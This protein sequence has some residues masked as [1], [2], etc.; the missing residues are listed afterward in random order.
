M[1]PNTIADLI[2][3]DAPTFAETATI[4]EGLAALRTTGLPAL[5]VTDERGRYA[6]IFGE[7]EFFAALFPGYVRDLGYAA[8]VPSSIAAALEKRGG[9]LAEPIG[10]WMH[11]DHLEA[12]TDVSDLQ[13]AETFLHHD[14]LI[15]PICDAGTVIGVITRRDFFNALADRLARGG[16]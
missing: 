16:G 3:R 10:R 9:C 6:G 12:S 5:A 13:L 7:R 4:A 15:V 2:R 1:S 8:F 14:V 11:A